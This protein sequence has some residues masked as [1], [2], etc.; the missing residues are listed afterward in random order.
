MLVD[1]LIHSAVANKDENFEL[2][3]HGVKGMKWG[4]RKYKD[5]RKSAKK[6]LRKMDST[7]SK[8]YKAEMNSLYHKDKLKKAKTK[9]EQRRFDNDLSS[10]PKS[11][12]LLDKSMARYNAKNDRH[13]QAETKRLENSRDYNKAAYA[14]YKDVEKAAKLPV[15]IK[16]TPIRSKAKK[17]AQ[18]MLLDTASNIAL[19]K[20]G[21]VNGYSTVKQGRSPYTKSDRFAQSVRS[22]QVSNNNKKYK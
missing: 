10:S 18:T 3:H 12:K 7:S 2:L 4:V 19:S 11:R 5:I 8:K 15:Q 14:Y 6:N 17:S 16:L 9:M 22:I 21:V 1:E 20:V 13:K